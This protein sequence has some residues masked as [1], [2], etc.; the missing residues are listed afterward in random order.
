MMTI[1]DAL[2]KKKK[3]NNYQK[4]EEY[5]F[6]QDN[7]RLI[8]KVRSTYHIFEEQDTGFFLIENNLLIKA[9][10]TKEKIEELVTIFNTLTPSEKESKIEEILSERPYI[11]K[12]NEKIYLPQFPLALNY[13]YIHSPEKLLTYPYNLLIKS[14]AT[15]CIDLFDEYGYE[16]FSSSFCNLDFIAKD[17]TSAAFYNQNFETI[18]V[19]NDQGRLDMAIPLFDKY[20]KNKNKEELDE[21]LKRVMEKFYSNERTAFIKALLDEK[22]I[23][24]KMHK[25]L[26]KKVSKNRAKRAKKEQ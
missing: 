16:L 17:K 13:I 19:I 21:R 18:Y 22:L 6:Y 23:S 12:D 10:I 8:E 24:E 2:K 14:P 15:S 1:F 7:K 9:F 26:I 25:Y 5:I 4:T 11:E 20:L 3:M